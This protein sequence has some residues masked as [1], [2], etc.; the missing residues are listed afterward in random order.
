[1]ATQA[2]GADPA[3]T[4]DA[5]TGAPS[6]ATTQ[7]AAT[8]TAKGATAPRPAGTGRARTSAKG[9]QTRARLIAAARI[10][11]A[12]GEA[13]RFTTRNVAALSGVSHGMCH[14]HFADRTD[15]IVAV[16]ADIRPEWITPLEEAVAGP[17]GYA[18]RAERVLTLLTRPES[19]DLARLHAALHWLALNDE[20]VRV[21]LEAEYGRWRSCFVRLFRALVDERGGDT[22]P[23]PLGESFAAAV[24]GIAAIGSLDGTVDAARVL[25]TLLDSLAST[26]GPQRP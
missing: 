15:L 3:T 23:A 22:D 26:V 10:L 8:G 17:G 2:T 11:L 25:R 4:Q 21:A 16:V 1:M 18:E 14:Y 13:G 6:A 12:G 19:P 24:D 7:D 9:E 5:V 20:R